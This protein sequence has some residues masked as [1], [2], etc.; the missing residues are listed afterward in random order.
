[1]DQQKK[2]LRRRKWKRF[3]AKGGAI[4]LIKK[5]RIIEVGKPAFV[6][7][8]P[9]IDISMGG[10]SAQYIENKQRTIESDTLAISIPAESV[11]VEPM[12]FEIIKDVEVTKMPDGKSIRTRCVQF[13]KLTDYQS[14]QLKSFIKQHTTAIIK[15]RRTGSR[16][17]YDDPRFEDEEYREM[18]ERR[19]ITERRNT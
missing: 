10:L 1:M 19:I 18:Y 13:G 14:F 16:R 7:L 11:Q 12:P 4:V 8:G 15:D 17:Q 5:T 3:R 6:E 2:T 9:L